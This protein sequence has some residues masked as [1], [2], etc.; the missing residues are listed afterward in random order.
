MATSGGLSFLGVDVQIVP[1]VGVV[2]IGGIF[3]LRCL[4]GSGILN[5][6][7]ANTSRSSG[8]S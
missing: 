4:L 8:S 5:G 3:F 2:A 1:A 7:I 6:A